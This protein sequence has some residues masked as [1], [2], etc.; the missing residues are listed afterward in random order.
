MA[1]MSRFV[2]IGALVVLLA[3][4]AAPVPPQSFS[5]SLFGFSSGPTSADGTF[6]STGAIDEVGGF[7]A[8][9]SLSGNPSSPSVLHF[10][11]TLIGKQG[12]ITL[13]GTLHQTTQSPKAS[14][15]TGMARL[16]G[17]TAAYE[18]IKGFGFMNLVATST[19]ELNGTFSGVRVN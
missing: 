2:S 19:G 16:V 12:S 4:W 7:A 8:T 1:A 6:S 17:G 18:G 15:I 13:A 3:S 10:T 11:A 14:A 9:W 5:M